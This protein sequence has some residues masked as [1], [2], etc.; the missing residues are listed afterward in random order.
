AYHLMAPLRLVKEKKWQFGMLVTP[1]VLATYAVID[2]S[3]TASAFVHVVDLKEKRPLVDRSYLGAPGPMV[4]V[5]NRPGE[6]FA[7]HSTTMGAA[8]RARRDPGKERY[9]CAI[10]TWELT[11]L[12]R[13]LK[14]D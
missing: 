14:L 3:Y 10:D 5:S 2:L 11:K 9:H 6:G 13:S 7:A 8:F 12:K 1:E 4:G